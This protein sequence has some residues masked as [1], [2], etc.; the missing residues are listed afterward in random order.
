MHP[1]DIAILAVLRYQP[2]R[3]HPPPLDVPEQ[4]RD[5][6]MRE[7]IAIAV[8]LHDGA[9]LILED[10]VPGRTRFQSLP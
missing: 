10:H 2:H 4:Q 8:H 7:V 1:D 5:V 3:L 6:E 9:G